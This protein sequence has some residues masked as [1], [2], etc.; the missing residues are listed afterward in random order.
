MNASEWLVV[1]VGDLLKLVVDFLENNSTQHTDLI[2]S[3]D[4]NEHVSVSFSV[5]KSFVTGEFVRQNAEC[6]VVAPRGTAA[7]PVL[8]RAM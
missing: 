1:N 7:L 4:A 8:V 2:H 3:F 6:T 5:D